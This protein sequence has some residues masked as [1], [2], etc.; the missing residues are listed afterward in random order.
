MKLAYEQTKVYVRV[1]LVLVVVVGGGLV[2]FFNRSHSVQVWFFGL[3][4]DASPVNVVWLMLCTSAATLVTWWV[5]KLGWGLWRDLIK[6]RRLKAQQAIESQHQAR[7]AELDKREQRID[8]KLKRALE[9]EEDTGTDST[10][11]QSDD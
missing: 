8:D 5:L 2:L 11:G 7:M 1:I 6:V 9:S 4:D 3:T 10:E